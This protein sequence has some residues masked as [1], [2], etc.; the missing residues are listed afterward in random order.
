MAEAKFYNQTALIEEA[1]RYKTSNE[2]LELL[3]KEFKGSYKLLTVGLG[4]R[5]LPIMSALTDQL[6]GMDIN[7]GSI[8]RANE[9]IKTWKDYQDIEPFKTEFEF[10]KN[11]GLKPNFDNCFFFFYQNKHFAAEFN[12]KSF[13]G[14]LASELFLHLNKK[15]LEG[16]IRKAKNN[17]SSGPL[18]PGKL[19]FTVYTTGN[20]NSLDKKFADFGSSIGI[21]KTDFIKNGVVNIRNFAARVRKKDSRIYDAYKNS[22]W[23]DLGKVRGFPEEDIEELCEKHG[24]NLKGKHNI[25]CGMF[26]FAHRLVYVYSNS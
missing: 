17:L 8:D 16:V 19:I 3:F 24:F 20:E 23:L 9:F 12:R 22:Y 1:Q 21:K 11:K 15:D 26:P 6:I 18:E 14:E 13:A 7:Q 10:L 5:L 25:N 2:F 4:P